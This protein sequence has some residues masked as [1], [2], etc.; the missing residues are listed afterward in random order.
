VDDART[1]AW[2]DRLGQSDPTSNGQGIS[3]CLVGCEVT[4]DVAPISG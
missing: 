2:H 3:P 1:R 4:D